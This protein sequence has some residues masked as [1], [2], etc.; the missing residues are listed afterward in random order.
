MEEARA[1]VHPFM[2]FQC[3]N[4]T[5]GCRPIAWAGKSH[6][7]EDL[8]KRII[9]KTHILKM[10][11]VESS[12]TPQSKDAVTINVGSN[13]EFVYSS[14]EKVAPTIKV[15]A[16]EKSIS[17]E[18]G[19]ASHG[20]DASKEVILQPGHSYHGVRFLYIFFTCSWC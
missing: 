1:I 8:V 20:G 19:T 13:D 10:M 15:S 9:L 6:G 7:L 11:S 14:R 2:N 5:T 16:F 3:S 4:S 12:F 18:K 17:R